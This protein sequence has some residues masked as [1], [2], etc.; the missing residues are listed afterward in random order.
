LEA[1][2]AVADEMQDKRTGSRRWPIAC[3]AR[4]LAGWWQFPRHPGRDAA[5]SRRGL[6]TPVRQGPCRSAFLGNVERE[7]WYW[8]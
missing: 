6:P 4:R 2:Q 5:R 8:W 1:V 3:R 7:C